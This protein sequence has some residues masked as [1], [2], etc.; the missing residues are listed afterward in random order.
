MTT[1]AANNMA[2]ASAVMLEG[3]QAVISNQQQ[4]D[5]AKE[6]ETFF[7]NSNLFPCIEVGMYESPLS[8]GE[9]EEQMNEIEKQ[10]GN[11][12]N[13]VT[14]D[15][16]DWEKELTI[17]AD[18]YLQDNIIEYLENYGVLK[19]E[20]TGIWSPRYYNYHNDELNMTI[21]MA[22]NWRDIMKE[23]IE[24]WRGRQ[25]VID[26]IRNH[27]HSCSGFVSF[28]PNSLDEI[29]TEDD[30]DRQLAAYLTLALLTENALDDMGDGSKSLWT[31]ADNMNENFSDYRTVNIIEEYYSDEN[32]AQKII[33]L[34]H[35]DLKWN[36]L[37]WDLRH[38]IGSPWTHDPGCQRLSGKKD[39]CMDFTADSDGKKLLF[40]AVRQELTVEDL[41]NMAA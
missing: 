7:L 25:D 11:E 28:M 17:Q 15:T 22:E 19:I 38:K 6:P 18:E 16:A 3:V 34:W 23:K 33:D 27:W 26:Y 31:L 37:Y 30:E 21:Q 9:F 8:P 5:Q 12:F 36:D 20:A 13:Y 35:D 39:I 29:L 10:D 40:W 2:A 4:Q 32:E 41:M 24:A 14:L 1:T